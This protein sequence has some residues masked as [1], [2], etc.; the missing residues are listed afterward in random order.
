[1]VFPEYP[2]DD[3]DAL[4]ASVQR[5]K[6]AMEELEQTQRLLEV[7]EELEQKRQAEDGAPAP[8]NRKEYLRVS[9]TDD[10]GAR[11]ENAKEKEE[12]FRDPERRRVHTLDDLPPDE[13]DFGALF[14]FPEKKEDPPSD[15]TVEPSR[16]LKDGKIVHHATIPGLVENIEL[17]TLLFRLEVFI[18][19]ALLLMGFGLWLGRRWQHQANQRQNR[20]VFDSMTKKIAWLE[21]QVARGNREQ[22]APMAGIK[23]LA[24]MIESQEEALQAQTGAIL[25]LVARQEQHQRRLARME[26]AYVMERPN[27]Q[28][29]D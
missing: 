7:I 3:F 20:L 19:G 25:Q 4:F 9:I 8:S 27:V 23:A 21:A 28:V 10:E 11:K 24:S 2:S 13:L 22:M 16:R 5:E 29:V 18:L 6:R 15:I 26:Q 17:D 12:K 14:G 1:M